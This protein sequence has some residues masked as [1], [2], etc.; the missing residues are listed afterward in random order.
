MDKI[1]E[2][3]KKEK[4]ARQLELEEIKWVLSSKGGRKFLWRW[5]GKCGVYSL[6]FNQHNS[7][8][9]FNEGKRSIGNEL[10]LE[11]NEADSKAF[12]LMMQENMEQVNEPIGSSSDRTG[13]DDSDDDA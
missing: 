10:M 12:V 2:A 9:S 3:R 1:K 6:S 8:M 7:V 5:L 4:L 13:S 11:I